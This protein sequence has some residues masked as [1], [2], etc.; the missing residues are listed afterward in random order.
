MARIIV[1][2]EPKEKQA[3]LDLAARELRAP[4]DQAAL[5]IRDGLIRGGAL[6]QEKQVDSLAT[7]LEGL[8][9]S[10]EDEE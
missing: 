8:S 2:L 10:V 7:L 5:F 3:L 4:R 1:N 9:K 6:S